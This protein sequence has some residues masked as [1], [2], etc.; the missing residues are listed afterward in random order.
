MCSTHYLLQVIA[1]CETEHQASLL[2]EKG[3]WAALVYQPKD[4][5]KKVKEV[6]D[7]KGVHLVFD[8]VGGKIFENVSKW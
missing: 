7:G 3:A 2:R 1:I 6:T 5:L 8:A 4:V